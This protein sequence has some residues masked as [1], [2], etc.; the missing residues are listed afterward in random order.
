L[1]KIVIIDYQLLTTNYRLASHHKVIVLYQISSKLCSQTLSMKFYFFFIACMLFAIK[2]FSQNVGVGTTNPVERLDVNG[3]INVTGTIKASG[4]D[5]TPNQVLMKNNSGN[6]AW[7]SMNE[8]PNMAS[9]TDTSA[10]VQWP[11]PNGVTKIWVELWGGGGAG[12]DCGGGGGGYLS[13]I[14]SIVPGENV[15]VQVGKGGTDNP[16]VNGL[17][18][19]ARGGSFSR[20]EHAGTVYLAY[21]GAASQTNLGLSYPQYFGGNGGTYYVGTPVSAIP[22]GSFYAEDGQCGGTYSLEWQ[23]ITSNQYIQSKRYGIGGAGANTNEY[24]PTGS[25]EQYTFIVS[26]PSNTRTFYATAKGGR[27]PA[28]GGN[29][30]SGLTPGQREGANGLVIIHY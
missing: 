18:T 16:T 15:H 2:S 21:G 24:N 19:T 29:G 10:T 26:P 13:I 12:L 20:L 17:V 7:G 22:R 5:G 1:G 23:S 11:V 3:N 6:L 4:V 27:F 9:F 30:G 25:F 8:F 14:I 28:G